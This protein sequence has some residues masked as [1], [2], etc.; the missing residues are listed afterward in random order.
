MKNCFVCMGLLTVGWNGIV[1]Q[2]G[3]KVNQHPSPSKKSEN[4]ICFLSSGSHTSDV[5]PP[6]FPPSSFTQGCRF[7]RA[8]S[9]ELWMQSGSVE[10]ESVKDF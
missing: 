1:F 5:T 8:Y 6:S 4:V 10:T 7:C 9:D 2:D 3:E